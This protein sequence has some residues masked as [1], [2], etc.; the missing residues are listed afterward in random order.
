MKWLKMQS[1][2]ESMNK[3]KKIHFVGIK[4]VGMTPL[5]IIAKEAGIKVSGSDVKEKFITDEELEEVGI[6]PFEGFDPENINDQDLVIATA[7]H[8]GSS[9]IEVLEAEKKNIPILNQGQALGKFQSGEI[10]GKDQLGI[11][12]AGSHGKTTTTAILSTILVESGQDPS[13]V[14]GTGKIPSL[15][16]SGHFGRGRY[17]IVEADE[18]FADVVT[19]RKPKF[20]YQNPKLI[21]ITNIDFDHPDVFPSF[22]DLEKA[23]LDFVN[24]LPYDGTLIA[25]GDGN[26]NREFLGKYKG[27]KITYGFSSDNDYVLDRVNFDSEKMFFWVKSN[28][29]VLSQFSTQVFGE[30][31]AKNCLGAIVTSLELGLSLE[32]I[33]KG[34][35]AFK[36]TKRRAEFIGKLSFG[37][38]LYDDYA[39]HPEEVKETI[40]A[41]KKSFSK[42]MLVVIFQ[43]HMY[44]RTKKLINEFISSFEK[45]DEVVITKIFPS[46]REKVDN[47]FSSKQIVVELNKNTKKATYF[48]DKNDVVKYIS[49]QKYP[50]NTIVI[51]MGAGDIYKIGENLLNG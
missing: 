29:I 19:D 7:A 41:F 16:T 43:P 42:S 15:G 5:A 37:G 10:L 27:Q 30:H 32:Q 25:C 9:N 36:G 38:L 51:T 13:F 14:V 46:F 8:G 3:I 1:K 50:E 34:I 18:Y 40:L 49:S 12:V 48:E 22:S 4:G 23:Y 33:K 28:D 20:L 35:S 26:K 39:H 44:S 31:N 21:L 47:N 17:F 45:A 2:I 6:T 24:K 11:S